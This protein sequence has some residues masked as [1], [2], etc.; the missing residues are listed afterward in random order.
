MGEGRL[1][2]VGDAVARRTVADAVVGFG[3]SVDDT[4]GIG[5]GDGQSGG[6]VVEG[7]FGGLGGVEVALLWGRIVLLLGWIG[8]LL[9]WVYWLLRWISR[10]LQGLRGLV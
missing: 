8:G 6:V 7:G 9:W 10:S 2:D 4:V 3:I 5:F 1:A